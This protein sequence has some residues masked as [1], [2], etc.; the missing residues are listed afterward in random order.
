MYIS[1]YVR[2]VE[3]WTGQVDSGTSLRGHP[4]SE[5]KRGW[6]SILQ[7][8][9]SLDAGIGTPVYNFHLVCSFGCLIYPSMGN[10]E[11]VAVARS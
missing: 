7:S 3:L 9:K 5:A 6:Q 2:A 11:D 8:V 4:F 1:R 10:A